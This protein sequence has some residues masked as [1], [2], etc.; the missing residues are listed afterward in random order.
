MEFHTPCNMHASS[1]SDRARASTP[2]HSM[3]KQETP[4]PHLSQQIKHKP[5]AH[6]L[7]CKCFLCQAGCPE[8]KFQSHAIQD[9]ALSKEG[10]AESSCKK[11]STSA[12]PCRFAI[13]FKPAHHCVQPWPCNSAQGTPPLRT[14]MPHI[15]THAHHSTPH[16]RLHPRRAVSDDA[17]GAE[18]QAPVPRLEPRKVQLSHAISLP[19]KS[20]AAAD[21]GG[22]GSCM[23]RWRGIYHRHMLGRQLAGLCSLCQGTQCVPYLKSRK[24][25]KS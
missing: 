11:A 1:D 9:P 22:K 23:L 8:A 5:P 20:S 10:K 19:R 4:P 24:E 3:C 13:C 17:L 7:C 25:R 18:R 15:I 12:I 14:S 2:Q 21:F 16:L 6:A